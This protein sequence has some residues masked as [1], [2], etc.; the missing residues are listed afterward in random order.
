MFLL[1]PSNQLAVVKFHRMSS[2]DLAETKTFHIWP[3]E[4]SPD[5]HKVAFLLVWVAQCWW[6]LDGGL[7]STLPHLFRCLN[8]WWCL[9]RTDFLLV[10]WSLACW[11]MRLMAFGELL[12]VFLVTQICWIC[13]LFLLMLYIYIHISY[14]IISYHI[15]LNH[16]WYIYIYTTCMYILIYIYISQ[17]SCPFAFPG[18]Q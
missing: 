4:S 15:S 5:H 1:K 2:I 13:W 6:V 8:F 12:W 16:N 11:H 18:H 3:S 14:H 17:M 7:V 9:E 10:F